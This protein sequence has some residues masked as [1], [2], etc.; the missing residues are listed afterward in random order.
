[1]F[2]RDRGL[3]VR[4][5]FQL[6][7]LADVVDLTRI[8]SAGQPAPHEWEKGTFNDL[9]NVMIMIVVIRDFLSEEFGQRSSLSF[10]VYS[11]KSPQLLFK[12][13]CSGLQG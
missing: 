9:K 4:P 10:F 8:G 13:A 7:G 5:I 6:N 1:M 12:A 2:A 3:I 11:L